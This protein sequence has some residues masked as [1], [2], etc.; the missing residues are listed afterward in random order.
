MGYW[1]LYLHT[2]THILDFR[3]Y[4]TCVFVLAAGFRDLFPWKGSQSAIYFHIFTCFLNK[5]V[6]REL[7]QILI[8]VYS[9]QQCWIWTTPRGHAANVSGPISWLCSQWKQPQRLMEASLM[10]RNKAQRRFSCFGGYLCT[11]TLFS[12]V[13]I[14]EGLHL[15]FCF[16][17]LP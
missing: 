1:F 14:K 9:S 12:V 5:Q 2:H 3:S 11:V 17:S 8:A 6:Q 10:A 16:F 4:V 15:F 13:M 7:S